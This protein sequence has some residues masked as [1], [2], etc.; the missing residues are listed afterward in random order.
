MKEVLSVF[1][2]ERCASWCS[3]TA[4]DVR[5]RADEP[6]LFHL[7]DRPVRSA[8]FA[9]RR[10]RSRSSLATFRDFNVRRLETS[11]RFK[12]ASFK[13][14]K[15]PTFQ[16]SVVQTVEAIQPARTSSPLPLA[17]DGAK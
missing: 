7:I 1:T 16:D 5:A 2:F 3:L 4:A 15:C 14:S 6:A 11:R 17:P 8:H 13:E 12:I 10:R 9:R